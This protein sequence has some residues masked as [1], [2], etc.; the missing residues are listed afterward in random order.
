MGPQSRCVTGEVQIRT[1]GDGPEVVPASRPTPDATNL[2]RSTSNHQGFRIDSSQEGRHGKFFEGRLGLRRRF[3]RCPGQRMWAYIYLL[4]VPQLGTTL[5]NHTV[6]FRAVRVTDVRSK[7]WTAYSKRQQETCPSPITHQSQRPPHPVIKIA[8][9]GR[10]HDSSRQD[11]SLV[12]HSRPIV[13][14]RIPIHDGERFVGDPGSLATRSAPSPTFAADRRFH[15]APGT[16]IEQLAILRQCDRLVACS[17]AACR[18]RRV[19]STVRL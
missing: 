12:L 2:P 15:A 11:R 8:K 17:T 6:V 7:R 19:F 14:S 13:H 10:L 1:L 4:T 3:A 16:D 9:S 5:P 18:S